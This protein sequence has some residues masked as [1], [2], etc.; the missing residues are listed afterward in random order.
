MVTSWRKSERLNNYRCPHSNRISN[1]NVSSVNLD[2]TDPEDLKQEIIWVAEAVGL[3]VRSASY[4]DFIRIAPTPT[5]TP[6]QR[7]H[8]R[9]ERPGG[10]GHVAI[11][12]G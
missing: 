6:A 7:D 11:H 2:K 8:Q 3:L 5:N 1:V 12:V 10:S 4:S 9:R